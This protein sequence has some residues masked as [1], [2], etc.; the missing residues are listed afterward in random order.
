M[1]QGSI[2]G[3][4][5]FIL[6]V[7]GATNTTKNAHMLL[8]ADDIILT[9]SHKD[10]QQASMLLQEDINQLVKWCTSHGMTINAK[11]T[12]TVWYGEGKKVK[13]GK[14]HDIIIKGVPLETP[15]EYT[16]LGV[17]LDSQLKLDT[18]LQAT[19]QSARNKIFKLSKL[20]KLMSM[21]TAI[22]VYKQTILAYC[23]FIM[24]GENK[25]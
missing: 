4:L 3:P 24:E 15:D 18:Q 23:S 21:E 11:K 22:L 13:A 5:L 1:P 12:K 10:P 20:R 14:A 25:N 6:Y 8:Y 9:V 16:Y 7:N 17:K 19:A 2:L